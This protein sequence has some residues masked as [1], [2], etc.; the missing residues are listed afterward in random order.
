MRTCGALHARAGQVKRRIH[1]QRLPL[2]VYQAMALGAF[3][4]VRR[5]GTWAAAAPCSVEDSAA[6]ASSEDMPVIADIQLAVGISMLGIAI[7]SAVRA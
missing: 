1:T 7:H 2:C 4:Q 6:V 5:L 3:G